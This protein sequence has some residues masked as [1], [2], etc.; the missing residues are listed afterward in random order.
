MPEEPGPTPD[1]ENGETGEQPP[2][3]REL[4]GD[5]RTDG[6]WD[7]D[8]E[9]AKGLGDL[10]DEPA[11]PDALPEYRSKRLWRKMWARNKEA[12]E[13]AAAAA[14]AETAATTPT[15]VPTGPTPGPPPNHSSLRDPIPGR[16]PPEG[17]R[18]FWDKWNKKAAIIGGTLLLGTAAYFIFGNQGE[19][20]AVTPAQDQTLDQSASEAPGLGGQEDD[21]SEIAPGAAVE[22]QPLGQADEVEDQPSAPLEVLGF[23]VNDPVDDFL[24]AEEMPVFA[25]N[26]NPDPDFD[27]TRFSIIVD[28]A[29]NQTAFISCFRGPVQGLGTLRLDIFVAPPEGGQFISIIY[30]YDGSLKISDPPPGVSVEDRSEGSNIEFTV[31]GFTP[32]DGASVGLSALVVD[33]GPPTIYQQDQVQVEI[34]YELA[35]PITDTSAFATCP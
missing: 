23:A 27:I 13:A 26:S 12:A 14:A 29:A 3:P 19:P 2:P 5:R 4:P 1:G 28:E 9:S 32:D 35:E 17:V 31:S 25:W 20:P 6:R 21:A 30:D 22:E 10:L 24:A 16:A 8:A 34:D 7:E 18:R 11:E 33:L 15:P